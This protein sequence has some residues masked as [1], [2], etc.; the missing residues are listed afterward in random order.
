M[1]Y[2]SDT[3]NDGSECNLWDSKSFE[4]DTDQKLLGETTSSTLKKTVLVE[5]DNTSSDVQIYVDYQFVN[6]GSDDQM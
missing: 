1:K 4:K 2:V 3:T 5:D 6:S